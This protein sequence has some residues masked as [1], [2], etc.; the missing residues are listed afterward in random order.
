MKNDIYIVIPA[1]NEAKVIREVITEIKSEGFKK[2]IVI[3]DGS[4]DQTL[5]EAR[6]EKVIALKHVLNRGK[7]AAIKTGIEAAQILEAN[8]VVT[9]DGDGQHNPKDIFKMLEKLDQGYDVILGSRFADK[10]TNIPTFKI[11]ENYIGNIVTWG[12]YGLFVSDSQ[13]G[14][15]AYSKHA[16]SLID[17]QHNRYE[18]DSEVIREISR[19]KL[20]YTEIP[21]EAR[22]TKYSMAKKKKQNIINGIKT[23]TS[24]FMSA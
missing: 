21:I 1:Y 19:N 17:L 15:R 12:I 13:S 6:A 7:G 20:K 2:I 5:K 22:F 18:Y 8:I 9:M 3:D 10:S 16:L 24:M 4:D 23:L 11:L 14:F